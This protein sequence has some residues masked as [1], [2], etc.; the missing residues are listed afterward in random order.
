MFPLITFD[1]L[2]VGT[3]ALERFTPN[4]LTGLR[5]QLL[6]TPYIHVFSGAKVSS[7]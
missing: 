5:E 2:E 7:E 3:S 4:Y 1:S 6:A